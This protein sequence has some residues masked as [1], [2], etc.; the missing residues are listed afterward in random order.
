M[1]TTFLKVAHH[2]ANKGPYSQGY[3]FSCNHILMWELEH[4]EGSAKELMLTSPC[5]LWKEN[6][7][8]ETGSTEE[9]KVFIRQVEY[10]QKE[11]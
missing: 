2:F 8:K 11:E 10:L 9:I 4:K 5:L 7:D 6:S 3:V 1:Y